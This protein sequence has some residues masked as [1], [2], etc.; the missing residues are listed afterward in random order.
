MEYQVSS[1]FCGSFLP[2][3]ARRI[4]SSGLTPGL[5]EKEPAVLERSRWSRWSR[6]SR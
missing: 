4:C 3:V 5:W 2:R 1:S 6:W